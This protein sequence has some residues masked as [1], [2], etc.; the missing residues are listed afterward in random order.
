[1]VIHEAMPRAGTITLGAAIHDRFATSLGGRAEKEDR[2]ALLWALRAHA[3]GRRRKAAWPQR[4][5]HTLRNGVLKGAVAR[6]GVDGLRLAWTVSR[7]HARKYQYLREIDQG[8]HAAAVTA[9]REGRLRELFGYWAADRAASRARGTCSTRASR[10]RSSSA[11]EIV[12]RP[13]ENLRDPCAS[14][15]DS[16]IAVSTCEGVSDPD[17]HAAPVETRI[18]ARSSAISSA[19]PSAPSKQR[20]RCSAR[21]APS[22]F[23]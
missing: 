13:S 2:Y 17:A 9:L 6:G 15:G 19:S 18:P 12:P 4:L 1:M 16:P 22:P 11:S 10:T 3:E 7:Y 21:A 20:L 5:A 14:A 8:G 23:T